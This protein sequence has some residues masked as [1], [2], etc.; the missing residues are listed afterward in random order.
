MGYQDVHDDSHRRAENR[1]DESAKADEVDEALNFASELMVAERD[2]Q[3]CR[4]SPGTNS[5]HPPRR[6]SIEGQI[7]R[8][9]SASPA[10]WTLDGPIVRDGCLS[11]YSAAS[12]LT[13]TVFLPP[14]VHLAVHAI[15]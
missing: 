10:L 4:L 13:V 11:T 1:A 6:V 8:S 7:T 12:C 15:P 14:A 2:H 5:D 9:A 3:S